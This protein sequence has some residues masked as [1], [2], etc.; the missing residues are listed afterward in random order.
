MIPSVTIENRKAYYDFEVQETYICGMI[1]TGPEV[2]AI[3]SGKA[4]IVDAYVY[5]NN[6]NNIL[7]LTNMEVNLPKSAMFVSNID[8]KRDISLLVTG[9]ELKDIKKAIEKPGY[10]AIPLKIYRDKKSGYFKL[11]M[12]ICKGKKEYD[13]RETIKERD[14]KREMNR[15]IKNF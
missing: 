15:A 13:K 6:Q 1:L 4:N 2:C 12:G 8:S 9:K 3:R 7:T 5:V 10:T 11:L 14:S